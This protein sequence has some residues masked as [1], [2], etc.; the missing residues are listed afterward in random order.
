VSEADRQAEVL[1]QFEA[2][3]GGAEL[4]DLRQLADGLSLLG[5]AKARE[6]ERFRR[7]GL[8]RRPLSELQV[9]RIRVDLR[10][11][12]PPIWRRLDVRSDLT[13]DV[14]H[15][16]LQA[17]FGWTD[18]HLWRFSLG[19]DPFDPSS[20]VFLCPWDVEEGESDDEGGMAAATVRLDETIQVPG[21]ILSYVYDYGDNWEL[22]LRLES[23]LPAA[24]GTPSAVAVDGRRAAPPED[25]GGCRTADE[26]AEVLDHPSQFDLDEVN[27]VL[28]GPFIV[29]REHGLDP[30]LV[31]VIDRLA[32]SPAGEELTSR[33]FALL[34]ERPVPAEDALRA[35]LKPFIWFLDRAAEGGIA[36]TAAGYLK[37]ADVAAAAELLPAM[38]GWI[39]KA[40]REHDTTPVLHF[41]KALQSLGLLRK[42]KGSLQLTRA[43]SEA[44]AAWQDLWN[45]LADRLVPSTEGFE[46]DATLLLLAYAATSPDTELPLDTIA[47]ALTHLGWQSGDGT[48]IVG[49]DLYRLRALEILRNISHARPGRTD[50]CRISPQAAELARA[51]LRKP[52]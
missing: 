6:R 25:C 40:N 38:D 52:Q 20:Q 33:A 49:Y 1:R 3:I 51:A 27:E 31:D 4:D 29:L 50:R 32:Y 47:A 18:S 39:G 9:F 15:R 37:P 8:R 13:L 26:L 35:S 10:H 21:E 12:K 5:A 44:Q 45:R 43:G 2:V 23:V 24:P 41:R 17:A 16:V 48:P 22:T 46:T 14:L 36:L 28:Q 7:P 34:Q 19:G 30:R 42:H 11:A